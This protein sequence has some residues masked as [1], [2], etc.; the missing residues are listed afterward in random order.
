MICEH[1][2]GK[3]WIIEGGQVQLCSECGGFGHLHCCDGLQAQPE[4]CL[5]TEEPTALEPSARTIAE[6]SAPSSVLAV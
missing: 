5:V 1:C 6:P 3:N 4:R 2:H